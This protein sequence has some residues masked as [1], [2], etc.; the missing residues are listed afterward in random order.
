MHQKTVSSRSG[1]VILPLYSALVRPPLEYCV[2][3]GAPLFK[4]DREL[5][6]RVH[7]RT[8]KMT[9]GLEHH[10]YEERLN[11]LGLFSLEKIRLRGD[12]INTYKYLKFNCSV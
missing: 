6:K 8:T 2:E 10:S 4:Q 1:E 9:G 3:F 11:Y 12:L 5:L 7:Q